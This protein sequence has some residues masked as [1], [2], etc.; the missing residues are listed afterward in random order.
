MNAMFHLGS[1]EHFSRTWTTVDVIALFFDS[2]HS[3]ALHPIKQGNQNASSP[4]NK[5]CH[6]RPLLHTKTCRT[7]HA[8]G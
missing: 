2:V 7:V 3:V 6:S 5:H 4:C 8:S 1:R